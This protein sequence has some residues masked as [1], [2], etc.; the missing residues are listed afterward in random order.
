[1]FESAFRELDGVRVVSLK[2]RIGLEDGSSVQFRELVRGWFNEGLQRVILNLEEVTYIDS[3][4]VGELMSADNAF[5][6]AGRYFFLAALQP[7]LM[8]LLRTRGL[9]SKFYYYS[10][11]EEALKDIEHFT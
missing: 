1:M 9:L 10:T 6:Q 11:E 7:R 3:A 4:G 8:D 2:G 5:K